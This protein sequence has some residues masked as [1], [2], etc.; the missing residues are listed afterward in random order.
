MDSSTF[1]LDHLRLL[2]TSLFFLF[3]EIFEIFIFVFLESVCPNRFELRFSLKQNDFMLFKR[4]YG[5]IVKIY[6]FTREIYADLVHLKYLY[7]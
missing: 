5:F 6:R 1:A 2:V 4:F 3:L 7:I